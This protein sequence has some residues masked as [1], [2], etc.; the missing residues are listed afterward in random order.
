MQRICLG[1]ALGASL[2]SQHF[3]KHLRILV[4]QRLEGGC[5]PVRRSPLLLSIAKSAAQQAV[6]NCK[7]N[8]LPNSAS[9]GWPRHLRFPER[10]HPPVQ[11]RLP[12]RRRARS[13][14]G[15][16]FIRNSFRFS[17]RVRPAFTGHFP[18]ACPLRVR[19]AGKNS[20]E[21]A[22]LRPGQI[23]SFLAKAGRRK[24]ARH[25]QRGIER[26][27]YYGSRLHRGLVCGVWRAF[28]SSPRV[29]C[30]PTVGRRLRI[31]EILQSGAQAVRHCRRFS[32]NR[33]RCVD[34]VRTAARRDRLDHEQG[35][36][37]SSELNGLI[38]VRRADSKGI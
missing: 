1:P 37:G 18:R 14:S 33:A 28:D 12:Q 10:R 23:N 16:S 32:R 7:R 9:C 15:S 27:F 8:L 26:F 21:L 4:N 22:S 6:P 19:R 29:A 34:R 35:V 5:R 13:H 36:D 30:K 17:S 11:H 3:G 24:T 31:L 2:W 38:Q 25:G 20:H